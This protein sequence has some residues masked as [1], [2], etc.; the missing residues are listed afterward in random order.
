MRVAHAPRAK[1]VSN[2]TFRRLARH[3]VNMLTGFSLL[4]LRI[5]TITGFLFTAFG[6]VVLAY[7]VGRY[8]IQGSSVAGFP[9]LA[10]VIALFSGA[11]LFALGVIGEYIGRTYFQ[12]MGRPTYA[13]RGTTEDAEP[14]PRPQPD[15][16]SAAREGAR[17]ESGAGV[18][19]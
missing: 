13:V 6:V 5:A 12:V 3:A 7:V 9:F 8:L 16:T 19:R 1:G 10:S 18:R 17:G 11:Q 2:Y 4:P 14:A 15:R